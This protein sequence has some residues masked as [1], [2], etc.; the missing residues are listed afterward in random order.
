MTEW[1][2]ARLQVNIAQKNTQM[3][4]VTKVS[5]TPTKKRVCW[6]KRD[7]SLGKFWLNIVHVQKTFKE[8]S[9]DPGIPL[10]M[11]CQPQRRTKRGI[12]MTT[13]YWMQ[14]RRDGEALTFYRNLEVFIESD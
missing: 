4:H 13:P 8:H 10:K 6:K 9:T 12:L 2:L 5:I 11:E 1:E 3:I 7:S 14:P